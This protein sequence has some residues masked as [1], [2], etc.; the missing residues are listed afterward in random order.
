M[1]ANL[2]D[3]HNSHGPVFTLD[4]MGDG[5]EKDS[6]IFVELNDLLRYVADEGK[7]SVLYA[8][9]VKTH[10]HGLTLKLTDGAKRMAKVDGLSNFRREDQK[11]VV[12]ILEGDEKNGD[13]DAPVKRYL[14]HLCGKETWGVN[15]E[16]MEVYDGK[17]KSVKEVNVHGNCKLERLKQL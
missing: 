16:R 1:R 3:V 14:C 4:L 11:F 12:I 6:Q 9:F 13:G 8:Y 7:S 5:G 15:M 2:S 17:T 10:P